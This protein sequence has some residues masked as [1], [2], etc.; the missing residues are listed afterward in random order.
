M[1]SLTSKDSIMLWK[2]VRNMSP[3][4]RRKTLKHFDF[5]QFFNELN[6]QKNQ[7]HSPTQKL[8]QNG[9]EKS[10]R[11]PEKPA[12]GELFSLLHPRRGC[13]LIQLLSLPSPSRATWQ[14]L[15]TIINVVVSV[16]NCWKRK[17]RLQLPFPIAWVAGTYLPAAECHSNHK[18]GVFERFY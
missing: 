11:V 10:P 14:A 5:I 16:R 1:L 2:I 12:T 4:C 13:N 3:I 6:L 18:R 8:D 15:T 7:R 9:P 17:K